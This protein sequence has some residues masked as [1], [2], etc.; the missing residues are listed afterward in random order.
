M[1]EPSSSTSKPDYRV[2]ADIGGT[3][4]DIA[5][6]GEGGVIATKK[7]LSTPA[8][9]ALAVVDGVAQ[10][11]GDVDL[12]MASLAEVL[13]GTTVA[14]N[15]ILERRGARTALITTKGMRDV[16][17]LRRIR[18]P[19]LYDPLYEKPEPLVPR[20]L[21]LEVEER[22]GGKGDIVTPLN[23]DDV[24]AAVKAYSEGRRRSGGGDLPP[25]LFERRP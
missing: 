19:H 21:R 6:I 25:F 3:F 14:T 24:M 15:A 18:M 10:L 17:E 20:E 7:V 16:L 9:Y 13:H 1:A 2:A 8:D 23:V 5:I 11:L 22:I 12:P 4:T